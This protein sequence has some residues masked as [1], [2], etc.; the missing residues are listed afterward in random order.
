MGANQVE[1]DVVG[2]LDV[3]VDVDIGIDVDVGL[4]IDG[5]AEGGVARG[6]VTLL[7]R[8]DLTIAQVANDLV[9][10][11]DRG[12]VVSD[13]GVGPVV[14]IGIGVDTAAA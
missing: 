11:W 3:D 6:L 13:P 14:G 4:E 5:E 2:R 1:C 9:D 7:A 8:E 12:A 10:E